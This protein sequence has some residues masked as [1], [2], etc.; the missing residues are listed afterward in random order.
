MCPLGTSFSFIHVASFPVIYAQQNCVRKQTTRISVVDLLLET[1]RHLCRSPV[2]SPG[3][4]PRRAGREERPQGTWRG[5]DHDTAPAATVGSSIC[6]TPPRY[7][8]LQS[9]CDHLSVTAD[10]QPMAT[11]RRQTKSN[12][13]N[14][15]LTCAEP[16]HRRNEVP[17]VESDL[18][19][20]R[21][22]NCFS[23]MSITPTTCY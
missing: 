13:R 9:P 19:H 23:Q 20:F 15:Q 14:G 16:R 12:V 2:G 5:S 21:N 4:S 22:P 6:V 18:L 7:I 11:A 1:R 10:I 3:L 17:K 8:T